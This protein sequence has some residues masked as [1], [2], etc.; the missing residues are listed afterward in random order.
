MSSFL[1][2]KIWK[3]IELYFTYG[4]I[5]SYNLHRIL[6]FFNTL[7][8]VLVIYQFYCD[9]HKIKIPHIVHS[10]ELFFGILFLIEFVLSLIL[11]YIPNKIFFKPYLFLN[12]LV[13][14]SLISPE[15][16]GNIAFLRIIRSMKFVKF[17]LLRKKAKKEKETHNID[18]KKEK[19]KNE[20][21]KKKN[22]KL[23]KEKEK[24]KEN[25]KNGILDLN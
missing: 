14:V 25:R 4:N 17:Y 2:N 21:K 19:L 12:F 10:I 6:I 23:K 18:E 22:L 24:E 9:F 16:F 15:I 1:K 20:M 13:I 7:L 3:K 8:L 5:E 11:I